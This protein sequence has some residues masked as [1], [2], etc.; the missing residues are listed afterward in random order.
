[1]KA[2]LII[3]VLPLAALLA[4]P[5]ETSRSA[6]PAK[7]KPAPAQP[8]TFR[9]TPDGAFRGN[10]GSTLRTLPSGAVREPDGGS[11][12]RLPNGSWRH[13][14][15]SSTRTLPDGSLRTSEGVTLR[16]L[17][18]GSWSGSDGTRIRTLPGGQVQ[19]TPPTHGGGL[20]PA[21]A[22]LITQPGLD[23]SRPKDK[24]AQPGA[25]RGG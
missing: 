6:T 10:D 5:K 12:R 8:V 2:L 20:D 14:D 22:L 19:V 23:P 11:S 4:A 21:R 1:M 25:A 16:K 7:E 24:P 13:G 18:D 9:N 3:L 17:P 15:G